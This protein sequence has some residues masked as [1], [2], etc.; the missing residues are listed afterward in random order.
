MSLIRG[1]GIFFRKCKTSNMGRE[2]KH[3]GV[4]NDYVAK[5][6]VIIIGCWQSSGQ[7]TVMWPNKMA[8][9]IENVDLKINDNKDS[10]TSQIDNKLL[11]NVLIEL[12]RKCS[13]Y[14]EACDGKMIFLFCWHTE[15][16]ISFFD[17]RSPWAWTVWFDYFKPTSFSAYWW[18]SLC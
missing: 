9:S 12:R 18:V 13:A 8:A 11:N 14:R 1:R 17:Y 4:Q 5:K 2:V 15:W 7:C 16:I 3:L 6:T 10:S